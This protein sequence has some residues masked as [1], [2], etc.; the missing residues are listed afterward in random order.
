MNIEKL[1]EIFQEPICDN[2]LG[3]QYAQ[4]LSG[5]SNKER[6]NCLRLFFSFLIDGNLINQEVLNKLEPSNFKNFTFRQNKNFYELVKKSEIKKCKICNDFFK[7]DIEKYVEKIIKKLK[8]YEFSTFLV[9]T[10]PSKEML[11]SEEKLWEKIGISFCEPIKAEINREIGKRLEKNT[12]KK[13]ELKNPDISI[14]LD[15]NENKINFQVK[16]LFILGYYKKLK[17]G[18][19]Q[20]K[21]GT[22][23][24]YK[25]S[26][27]E[28]IGRPLLKI[29]K[30]KTHKFHGYGREDID[31]LCLGD[32]AFV[33]EIKEPRKRNIDLKDAM[34]KIN[35]S[36]KIKVKGLKIVDMNVVRKIKEEHGDKEYRAEVV[37]DKPIK[38]EDLKKLKNLIGVIEQRTPLRV[39]HRRSDLIRKKYVKKISWKFINSKKFE[40]KIKTNAGLYIK[41]LISGDNGRTKPSISEIL[42]RNAKCKK[43]DVIWLEKPKI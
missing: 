18:F 29:T 24:K 26:V 14:I 4:L 42:Q 30:G 31:A 32:R 41:E 23:G 11:N 1:S 19:P 33:I 25:T 7:E 22:P 6:G 21:W 12:K 9:G 43:L 3:R 13:A 20:C 10:K 37:L 2:C 16:S 39:S 34:K 27:E 36:N 5:F 35:K 15:L 40:I 28:E 38:K 17:R 8:E